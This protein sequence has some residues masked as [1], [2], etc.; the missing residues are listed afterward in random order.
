MENQLFLF[1]VEEVL[2]IVRFGKRDVLADH[3]Q[4]FVL[5]AGVAR[6]ELD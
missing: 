4:D 1:N 3:F 2:I 5:H 6:I